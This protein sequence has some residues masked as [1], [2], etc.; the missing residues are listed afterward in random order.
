MNKQQQ[1][2]RFEFGKNWQNYLASS[3]DGERLAQARADLLAFVGRDDLAGLSVL[4][5]GSGSGIHSLAAVDAGAA[6]VHSFDYDANSVAATRSMH[7]LRGHPE[8]WT[9]QQGSVLDDDFMASLG[10]FDLVYSWGVLHHTGEVWHA[11]AN[12]A[13][14]VRPGGLLFIA[15]YDSDWSAQPPQFWLAIKQRYTVSGSLIRRCYELWYVLRFILRF[16]PLRLGYLWNTAR[17]YKK[18]RG[19]SLYYDICD[20]LGGWPMEYTRIYE[21]LSALR[22][23]GFELRHLRIG[24]ANTEYLLSLPGEPQV[25]SRWP[26]KPLPPVLDWDVTTLRQASDFAQIDPRQPVY[27]YGA[28]RGAG[29]VRQ[30]LSAQGLAV[31]AFVTTKD[32]GQL[33]GLP[34]MPLSELSAAQRSSGQFIIAA[35]AFD[36]ISLTLVNAGISRFFNAFPYLLARLS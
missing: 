27:V 32:A 11:L 3:A 2:L 20:W 7:Q 33:D 26:V 15:L 30:A 17:N 8:Q 24:E 31:T 13:A 23:L 14:R 35:T 19:M 22:P 9:V 34:V 21:T 36:E 18:N 29:L 12:A 1:E 28:G 4:D 10:T 25:A 5:I 16:N 6:R